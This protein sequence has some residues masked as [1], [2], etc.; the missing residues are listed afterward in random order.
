MPQTPREFYDYI[1]K[2]MTAEEALMKLLEG[3]L[4][5]YENLKFSSSD[6]AV[7]PIMI[8]SMA[9]SDLGWNLAVEEDHEEIRGLVVGTQEYMD[10]IFQER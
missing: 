3:S 7:H 5:S 6:E 2:H 4:R 8:I 9:A 10:N 1:T